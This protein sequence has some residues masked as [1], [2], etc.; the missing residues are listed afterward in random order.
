MGS[1]KIIITLWVRW[2]KR[3]IPLIEFRPEDPKNIEDLDDGIGDNYIR[4]E[5]PFNS[6][7][8]EFFEANDINGLIQRVLA[9]INAQTA[10]LRFPQSG[11]TLDKI[12]HLYRLVL[13]WH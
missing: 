13:T 10:N 5:M 6:L 2:K 12:M 3:I 1:A 4:V 8:T 11:F 7:I 9:Y